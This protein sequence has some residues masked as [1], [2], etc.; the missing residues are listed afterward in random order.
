M[1]FRNGSGKWQISTNGGSA[2][3]WQR[4]GRQLFYLESGNIMAVDIATQPVF[5]V[6]TPRVIVPI[7]AMG[8]LAG[9]DLSPDGQR[10]LVVQ[11]SSGAAQTAQINVILN[12]SEELR[13][14]SSSAKD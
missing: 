4:D 9:Y 10:F 3:V 7:K 11:Q 1:P 13:R 14:R 12:W 6:S 8:N 5:K 2:P